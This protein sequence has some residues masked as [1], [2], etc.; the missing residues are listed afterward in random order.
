MYPYLG[1]GQ[2]LSLF[3]FLILL[4]FFPLGG[5]IEK[6]VYDAYVYLESVFK[7]NGS[8][9]FFYFESRPSYTI[10]IDLEMKKDNNIKHV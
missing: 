9:T 2:F 7:F 1:L 10:I 3:Y 8:V 6:I 4:I 5:P